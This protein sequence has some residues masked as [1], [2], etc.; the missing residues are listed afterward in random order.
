MVHCQPQRFTQYSYPTQFGT[1]WA[2]ASVSGESCD[3]IA[4]KSDVSGI[5]FEP[6]SIWMANQGVNSIAQ[7]HTSREVCAMGGLI[8]TQA[9]IFGSGKVEF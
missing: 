7:R 9:R 4:N 2:V 3:P 6:S 8:N 1:C 5:T